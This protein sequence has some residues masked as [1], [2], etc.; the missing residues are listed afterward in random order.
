[1]AVGSPVGFEAGSVVGDLQDQT[2]VI[3]PE[4]DLQPA[5]AGVP[6]GV[7][8]AL[9]EDQED[10]PSQVRPQ[11]EVVALPMVGGLHHRYTRKAA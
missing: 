6:D 5:A 2:I 9:L 3:D 10:L 1:M 4:R 7:V 11:G 8:D